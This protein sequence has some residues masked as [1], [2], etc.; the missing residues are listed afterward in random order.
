MNTVTG[1]A[2][3]VNRVDCCTPDWF[4]DSQNILFSWRPR[5]QKANADYGWT[6][7]WMA[8]GNSRHLVAVRK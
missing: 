8:E 2:N 4:P 7:L 5:G 6:Q 3:A 1:E